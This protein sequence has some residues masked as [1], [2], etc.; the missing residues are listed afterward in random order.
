MKNTTLTQAVATTSALNREQRRY[1]EQN[2][3]QAAEELLTKKETAAFYKCSLRQVELLWAAG[4][5][6][7]PFYLGES[8]PRWKRSEL[9]A[10]LERRATESQVV[11]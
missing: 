4:R 2:R 7:R 5:I 8:S 10:H 11:R 1:L 3:E 9:L 6:P